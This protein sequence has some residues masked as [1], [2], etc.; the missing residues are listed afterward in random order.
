MGRKSCM[1]DENGIA[2]KSTNRHE[3]R[4]KFF[5][6]SCAFRGPLLFLGIATAGSQMRLSRRI[7]IAAFLPQAP[8][9]PPPG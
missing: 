5:V 8:M 3:K 1:R 7:S 9:T 2:T 6:H 4:C